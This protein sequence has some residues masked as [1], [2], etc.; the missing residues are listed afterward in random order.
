MMTVAGSR[1]KVLVRKATAGCRSPEVELSK[2][3]V[4]HASNI[5]PPPLIDVDELDDIDLDEQTDAAQLVDCPYCDR[6]FQPGR[7][8]LAH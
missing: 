2:L 3:Y 5:A 1:W 6:K 7:G 4:L 8:L